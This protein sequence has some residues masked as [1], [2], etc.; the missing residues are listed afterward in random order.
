MLIVAY[1]KYYAECSSNAKHH[2][3]DCNYIGKFRLSVLILNVVILNVV[4]LLV[5]VISN[6]LNQ[7]SFNILNKLDRFMVLK[8]VVPG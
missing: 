4:A 5:H 2:Y 1:L 6:L 7:R 3:A 8:I